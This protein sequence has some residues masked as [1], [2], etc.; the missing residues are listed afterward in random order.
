MRKKRTYERGLSA[1]AGFTLVE[2]IVAIALFSVVMLIAVGALLALTGANRKAQALQSVMN[3][4]NMSLDS[5]VRTIRMGTE[6]HCSNGGSGPHA[7]D[8]TSDCNDGKAS[9]SFKSYCN[10]LVCPPATPERWTYQFVAP[11]SG[12]SGYIQRTKD[13]TTWTRLTAPEVSIE[14]MEF[15]VAGTKTTGNDKIQPKVLI[16]IQGI[17]GTDLSDKN[18]TEFH[19]QATAVQR[20]L[21][22]R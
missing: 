22:L 18:K 6:Y 12:A 11:Q 19:I 9:F 2:M 10:P 16:V 14:N 20:Q 3:N 4:L 15:Y 8:G 7:S 13:G 5:M 21:D 1:Q 17:A